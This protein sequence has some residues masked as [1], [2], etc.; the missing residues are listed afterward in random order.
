MTIDYSIQYITYKIFQI[1]FSKPK[2]IYLS[3]NK[4]PLNIELILSIM[5]FS[6]IL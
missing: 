2:Q 1:S 3:M 5:N 4:L 6:F